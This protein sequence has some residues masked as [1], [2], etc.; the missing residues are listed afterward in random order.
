MRRTCSASRKIIAALDQPADTDVEVVPL[1]HAVAADLAPL[2]Q[3]LG[4]GG[5]GRG[6]AGACRPVAAAAS[7]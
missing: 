2:V 3:R 7:R 4:D 1:Q 6:H 5:T